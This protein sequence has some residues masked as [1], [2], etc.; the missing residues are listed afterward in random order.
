MGVLALCILLVAATLLC[1][2]AKMVD[3]EAQEKGGMAVNRSRDNIQGFLDGALD[4]KNGGWAQLSNVYCIVREGKKIKKSRY[5]SLPPMLKTLTRL[6][7]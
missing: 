6:A 7:L 5:L 4:C 2:N 1:W 3:G